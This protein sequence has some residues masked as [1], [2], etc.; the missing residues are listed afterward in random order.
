MQRSV[1]ALLVLAAAPLLPSA[2]QSP[3]DANPE[4][5]TFAT[6][7]Y[8]MAPG[9]VEV[10]QGISAFGVSSYAAGTS[11]NVAIK[12][13]VV[14][15]VQAE[16]FGPF[17]ARTSGGVGVGDLG[18]SLKFRADLSSKSAIAVIPAVTAPTGSV[19][20]GLGAG[21]ALGS[22]TAVYSVDL[23][24]SLHFDVN[25]GPAGL[26]AGATQWFISVSGSWTMGAVG[27]TAECFDNTPGAAAPRFAG[28]LGALTFRLAPWAV[29]DAGGVRG[30]TPESPNS[31]FL[32]L[33]TNL[34]RAF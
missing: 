4:R 31:L 21:R 3:R 33:T 28:V 22:A 15:G 27:V 25:A 1:T 20:K 14:P 5:P 34:G 24:A 16:V 23:P 6:H 26:G 2:A 17:Y 13:G 18:L 30:T 9:Y 10:E 29:I 11:W 12:L 19:V 8:A 32:G 7:A